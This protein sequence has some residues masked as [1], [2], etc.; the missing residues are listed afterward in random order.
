MH[1]TMFGS[2]I[3]SPDESST[4]DLPK[5]IPTEESPSPRKS[6][7]AVVA[8]F[9]GHRFILASRVP[10]LRTLL[11][12]S[13]PTG[14]TISST[15]PLLL[16]LPSPPFTPA[17]LYFV[18]GF[19]YTGTLSFSDR[20][21]DLE[22]A[23]N[24]LCSAKYLRLDTLEHEIRARIVADM[25]HG[26]F[27]AYLPSKEYNDIIQASRETTSGC[28]CEQCRQNVLGILEFALR[29]DVCDDVRD[30][31]LERGARRALSKIHAFGE[32]W[33]TSEFMALPMW[34]KRIL[35]E[36]VKAQTT[37]RSL[38]GLLQATRAGLVN[39]ESNSEPGAKSVKNL[40][41][42]EQSR[43]DEVLCNSLGELFEQPE[44]VAVL[45]NSAMGP[46]EMDTFEMV[47]ESIGR[48]LSDA[49]IGHVYQVSSY[50]LA[51]VLYLPLSRHWPRPSCRAQI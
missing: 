10:F 31:I 17:C 35:L 8:F 30:D 45:H 36:D 40:I 22:T 18:L 33:T 6:K 19:I 32:A 25:A 13:T 23:F 47:M 41:I 39:L 11:S 37:P 34:S 2:V 42:E 5:I 38:L 49:N 12:A 43:I 21:W 14:R 16:N 50:E 9:S 4:D 15:N 26:L 1:T 44:W 27:H 7:Q 48:G 29:D 24:I 20:N 3:Q 28:L 46:G 51:P